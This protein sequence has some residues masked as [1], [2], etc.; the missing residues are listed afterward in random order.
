MNNQVENGEKR[1][2]KTVTIA[3]AIALLSI[4]SAHIQFS[5]SAP[6]LVLRYYK[7]LGSIGVI[8]YMVISG[9]Y[10]HPSRY[11]SFIGMFLN[12]VKTIG[13]P[14][15]VIGSL[16]YCYNAVLS[17]SFSMV[18]FLKYIIGNGSYLYFLT[19]LF[20]CFMIFYYVKSKGVCLAA[21]VISVIS[22]EL[23]AGGVL[24]PV[25]NVLHI[26]NYLN[27]LNWIGFFA[28]GVLLQNVDSDVLWKRLK[29]YRIGIIAVFCLIFIAIFIIKIP[30]GYFS[31]VGWIYEVVGAALI[32]AV[33]SYEILD[34]PLLRRVSGYSFTVY[35]IHFMIIGMFDGI[36]NRL[37]PLQ[38]LANLII[39]TISV[40]AIE[41][42][43]FVARMIKI[44]KIACI[45]LGVRK[46]TIEEKN[47]I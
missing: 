7:M 35:L 32:L 45:L 2:S 16:G 4:V 12:K 47:R 19:M 29:R 43:L 9:Y 21:M 39:I 5:E 3:R 14:W 15:I 8:A 6:E 36:Y 26:T 30:T 37:L 42:C 22:L 13:I 27:I 20:L 38:V 23:T 31:F 46:K 24:E 17:R 34:I 1:I 33:A 18:S 44:E 40:I 28:I 41:A 10:Y 11:V 25:I